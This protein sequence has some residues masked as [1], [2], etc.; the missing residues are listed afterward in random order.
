MPT[1]IKRIDATESAL[2]DPNRDGG[3]IDADVA[4]LDTGIAAHPELQI[5]GGKNCVGT[6]GYADGNGHGTHVAGTVAA[7]DNSTG[8]VG[9]APAA[10][11]WAVKVLRYDGGGTWS[12]V[13][14]GLDWVF[15]EQTTIDVVNMSLSGEY[16]RADSSTCANDALHAAICRVVNEAQIPVVVAAGNEGRNARNYAPAAYDEAITV[17]SFTDYN[18]LPGGRAAFTCYDDARKARGSGDDT[19]S[20]FSNYGRDVDILAPGGCIRSTWLNGQYLT[21]SGTSMAAPHVAGAVA[22]YVAFNPAATPAD[23]R[24]WLTGAASRPQ[25]DPTYGLVRDDDPDNVPEPILYLGST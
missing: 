18:G 6:E 14:C 21:I 8:V 13:I 3:A 1:G 20:R 12:S 9:V 22:L 11:L 16:A 15:A 23:V 4:V 19:F 2:A 24:V 17:S 25:M 7:R 10:R 5:A